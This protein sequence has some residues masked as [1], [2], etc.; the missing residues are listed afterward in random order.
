MADLY[1]IEFRG[2]TMLSASEGEY[3]PDIQ[4]IGPRLETIEM[5]VGVAWQEGCDGSC[6]HVLKLYFATTTTNAAT[7]W[8][9]IYNRLKDLWDG[10][11]GTLKVPDFP[12]LERCVIKDV[13]FGTQKRVFQAT[14]LN[15][16]SSG[17]TVGVAVEATV[18]FEQS[19]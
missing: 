7:I 8:A 6:E 14:P 15:S 12:D 13:K 11:E 17:F 10:V 9:N 19:A 5:P 1:K 4:I 16:A 18:T 3:E 2:L